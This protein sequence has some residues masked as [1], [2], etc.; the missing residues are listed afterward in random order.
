MKTKIRTLIAISALGI[1]GM[2]SISAIAD[3][4]RMINN[5]VATE[6]EELLTIESWMI[7]DSY[8]TSKS[9]INIDPLDKEDS[10]A[11]ESWMLDEK[12]WK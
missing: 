1:I 5:E 9:V 2:T 3:N 6:K 11:I 10:L 4:K 7:N 12:L 8:W